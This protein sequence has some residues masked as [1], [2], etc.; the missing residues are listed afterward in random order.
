MPRGR[1]TFTPPHCPN[2][3]CDSHGDPQTWRFKKKGF[4]ERASGPR[5]VQRYL[6]RHC[7]VN[8]SSQT[9]AVDY[10]LKSPRLLKSIFWGVVNCS[11]LRQL[12]RA[13]GVRHATIQRQVERL[14][15]HCLLLHEALR[16]RGAPTEAV[17]LDGF[18]TFESGQYWPFDL[19]LVVGSSYYVY[20]FNDAELRRS[21]THKP[22]QRAKRLRLETRFGRPDPQATRKAAQELVARVVPEGASVEIHSDAHQAYSQAFAQLRDREIRH[23]I[24]SSKAARTASN[25]LFP[26]NLADLLLRHGSANHKRETIAFSKRRQGALYRAA[27]WLVWRNYVQS[28]SERHRDAP[29]GVQIEVIEKALTLNDL[30]R[31]RRFPWCSNLS[32]WLEACYYA[33]IPTRAIPNAREHRLIYAV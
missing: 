3:D 26:V 23:H 33:R 24:T 29:P 16:P 25:P 18:R 22:R 19:Q 12:A 5:R 11:G 14:G 7:L 8:F 15:R 13:S 31:E 1:R 17:V 2:P 10:W 30:L 27:I 4:Y 32:G 20:A 9:F 28:R 6:C 21:G